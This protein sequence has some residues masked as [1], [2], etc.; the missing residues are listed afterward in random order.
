MP[1]SHCARGFLV[2]ALGL[3]GVF[4]CATPEP[5]NGIWEDR[6]DF[7]EPPKDD[8][9]LA[10]ATVG[11]S[12]P[13]GAISFFNRRDCPAGWAPFALA[14]GRTLVPAVG[15]ASVGTLSG[16]PLD[17]AE[18]RKHAHTVAVS[19]NPPG[20]N[21]AG[22]VG[23][24]N[25]GVARSGTATLMTTTG[26]VSSA[27]PYVQLLVCEKQASADRA[28][29]PAPAGLHAFFALSDCPEGWTDSG[30]PAGR[31]LVGLPAGGKAGQTFGGKA[32]GATELRPHQHSLKGAIKT[33]SYG[34]ALASGGAAGG[35][36][37]NDTYPYQVQTDESSV[38]FPYLML[39]QCK[40]I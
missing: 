7:A 37:K 22:I 40:K 23:G 11:D 16:K 36:A 4:G 38:E 19:I 34:I 25:T 18:D 33:S 6:E 8:V 20:V 1:A 32:L 17:D 24:G 9:D 27:L 10:P 21:Y 14:K 12:L 30:L 31:F 13:K 5:T 29:R 26:A 3:V 28:Q 2:G 15:V 35:Y 39:L